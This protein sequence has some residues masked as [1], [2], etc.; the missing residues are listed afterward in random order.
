VWAGQPNVTAASSEYEKLAL[1]LAM[2]TRKL[3]DETGGSGQS[4]V[5]PAQTAQ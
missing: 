3:A 4:G 1:K 5:G 2:I